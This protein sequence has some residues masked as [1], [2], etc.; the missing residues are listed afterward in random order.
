MARSQARISALTS[1][2]AASWWTASSSR[3]AA[4]PVGAARAT[5][6]GG[7]RR[8]NRPARPAG[9]GSAPPSS[10]CPSPGRRR[11]PTTGAARPTR[12]PAAG[13]P[14]PGHRTAGP[15]RPPAGPVHPVDAGVAPGPQVG[16]DLAFLPPVAVE[17]QQVPTSRSGRPSAPSSPVATSGLAES[18]SIQPAGSG[19]GR[20][21]RS[22]GRSTSAVTVSAMVARSVHTWPRRGARTARAAPS[23]TASSVSRPEPAQP[24]GD[25][26]VGGVEHTG[27]VEARRVPGAS[28]TRRTSNGSISA[29]TSADDRRRRPDQ[30]E[31]GHAAAVPRRAGR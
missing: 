18:R 19:Q 7:A 1:S 11:R 21:W 20:P 13:S 5:S 28:R 6:G 25:V 23:S 24:E 8:P 29:P 30:F 17:V 10:S 26:D 12:R 27:V 16:G 3:A 4:L 31:G 9:P 2:P 14:A 15:A 22:T